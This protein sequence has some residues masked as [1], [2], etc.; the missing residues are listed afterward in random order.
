MGKLKEKFRLLSAKLPLLLGLMVLV[1]ITIITIIVIINTR[2]NIIKLTNNEIDLYSES[3]SKLITSY[4]NKAIAIS[5]MLDESVKSLIGTDVDESEPRLKNLFESA[6]ISNDIFGVFVATE[7]NAIF[8]NTSSG[9]S[10]YIYNDGGLQEDIEH[11]YDRYGS[12]S[13]YT[14]ARDNKIIHITDPYEWTL[15]NGNVIT[16]ITMSN[17]V[18]DNNN[19][20][21]GVITCDFRID[22]IAGLPYTDGG[23]ANS[24]GVVLTADGTYINATFDAEM[25]GKQM[26]KNKKGSTEVLNAARE[27]IEY[28]VM[29]TNPFDGNKAAL[30]VFNP[31]VIEGTDL[32]WTAGF[33][34]SE[35]EVLQN[36]TTLQITIIIIGVVVLLLIISVAF[37]FIRKSL[38]PLDG[39]RDISNELSRG[40]LHFDTSDIKISND[41]IGDSNKLF[42]EMSKTLV[43]IIEDI[44]KFLSEVSNG[45]FTM[46]IENEEKYVGEYKYILESFNMI[47]ENL[48]SSMMEIRGSAVQISS[49][50]DQVSAAAQNLSQGATEQAASI[51]ELNATVQDINV[52]VKDNASNAIAGLESANLAGGK[53]VECNN[54]MQDLVSA[55]QDINEKS[56]NIKKI[57]KVIEDIAF[58]TNILALNAAVEAA[59]AGDAGKGF[60][61]VADEVRALAGKSA[62]AAANTTAMIESA[63][64]SVENGSEYVDV[65]ANVLNELSQEMDKL[66][67]KVDLI[68]EA[69]EQQAAAV[70][71]VT[72]GM[73][74]I[75]DVVQTNSATSE[76]TAA[77]SEEL[78]SQ[79]TLLEEIVSK[80]K[81]ME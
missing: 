71:Q 64:E 62:E 66:V 32:D 38:K 29:T 34:V 42:I 57:I 19:K 70:S 81:L 26:D 23:Y 4:M 80:Y 13:Y 1:G 63:I 25:A 36:V 49:G 51:E 45:N 15:S 43:E 54:Q 78:D 18:Y 58:Q 46:S 20:F 40:N 10:F 61:V 33:V 60:A 77:A 47:N 28:S 21:L 75:S 37:V 39:L 9:Y 76:E 14:T 44:Q 79:A 11:R 69:S 5:D 3:N 16:L 48:S 59:R 22:E 8:K 74:Q 41:E 30:S 56:E 2:S 12:E 72:V 53:V 73:D 52:K 35:H 50:A 17:P 68:T 6:I 7:R 31:V 65:T 55:M 67:Q 24:Y 27:K